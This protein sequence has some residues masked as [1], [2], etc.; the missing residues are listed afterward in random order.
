MLSI[1]R[2]LDLKQDKVNFF[3]YPIYSDLLMLKGKK[4]SYIV[5]FIFFL[6]IFIS[7]LIF[8]KGLNNLKN[9]PLYSYFLFFISFLTIFISLYFI[10]FS[11]LKKKIN[12]LIIVFFSYITLFFINFYLILDNFYKPP[13]FLELKEKRIEK[14]KKLKI[15]FDERS[16]LQVI[17]DLK[18]TNKIAYSAI[19]PSLSGLFNQFIKENNLMPLSGISKSL[20]V[21][22]N[23][24]GKYLIYQSDRYGF[25]N[26]DLIYNQNTIDYLIIGDS[27]AH[28][29]FVAEGEDV[30]SVLRKKG[31]T[32]ITLGMGANGPLA[33]LASLIEYGTHFKPK[34]ILW[35]YYENDLGDLVRELQ[36]PI[37][38]KY[39]SN[40][41]FS[42]NLINKQ[43]KIDEI[44]IKFHENKI[45]EFHEYDE[46]RFF[47][48]GHELTK[49]LSK[50]N[51]K[52]ILTLYN[53]R[54]L[55]NVEKGAFMKDNKITIETK[56]NLKKV[57]YKACKI[58]DK[59][60][61]Q[62]FIVNLSS[63]E[64]L[65]EGKTF[66]NNFIEDFTKDFFIK[67]INFGD[68]LLK[69]KNF[70]SFFPF[71][72]NGHYTKEGYEKLTEIILENTDNKGLNNCNYNNISNID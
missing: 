57:F 62:F 6:V 15:K 45:K 29:A 16:K 1:N 44:L 58:A 23:E 37:L 51:L 33:E 9:I 24:T 61:S 48:P 54:V 67:R 18:K 3:Y 25:N 38:K 21:Y 70:K 43:K 4:K 31:Y 27:F 13:I 56:E 60:N 53:I 65:S 39:I 35:F 52:K 2:I 66:S 72:M 42:Q 14:A 49:F 11:N 22:G 34:N 17:L 10:I 40:K 28:G 55:L 26:N 47:N 36:N 69:Q 64:A 59:N 50:N 12:F 8:F 63:F 5:N 7:F 32:A 19:L 71:Q 20:T 68:F 41:N 46:K 30:A